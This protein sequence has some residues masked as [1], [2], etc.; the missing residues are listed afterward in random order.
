MKE[1][2]PAIGLVTSSLITRPLAVDFQETSLPTME[3]PLELTE[4]TT[5][6][7]PEA[8]KLVSPT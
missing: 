8:E 1:S 2:D 3:D 6:K 5:T 4:A 7:L